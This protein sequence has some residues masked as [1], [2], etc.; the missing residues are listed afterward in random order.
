MSWSLD[1]RERS[2]DDVGSTRWLQQSNWFV[3][4][5]H[6]IIYFDVTWRHVTRVF[7]G[8]SGMEVMCDSDDDDDDDD[9]DKVDV[10]DD[11]DSDADDERRH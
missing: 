9:D 4:F 8:E 6:Y 10:D 5:E 11:E 7:D 3:Y 2:E 1:L